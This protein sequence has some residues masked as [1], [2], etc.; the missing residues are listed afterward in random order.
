MRAVPIAKDSSSI[1][2]ED[3]NSTCSRR[4]SHASGDG[5]VFGGHPPPNLDVKYEITSR[6]KKDS[7][8]AICMM[9]VRKYY[10]G[11]L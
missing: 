3:T 10:T 1:L 9:K 8:H 2:S 4:R 5:L 7:Y 11:I 6:D